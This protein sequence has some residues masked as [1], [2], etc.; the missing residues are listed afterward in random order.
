MAFDEKA[1]FSATSAA[2]KTAVLVA[3]ER[4]PENFGLII[5]AEGLDSCFSSLF[6]G[7]ETG[8]ML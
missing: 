4:N 5:V 7:H 8:A 6:A 1:N 3:T 2:M